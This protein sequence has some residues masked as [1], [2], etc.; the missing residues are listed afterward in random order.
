ML[1]VI[2]A[3]VVVRAAQLLDGL[4]AVLLAL[5]AGVCTLCKLVHRGMGGRGNVLGLEMLALWPW[6]ECEMSSAPWRS[7]CMSLDTTDLF[8]AEDIFGFVW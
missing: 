1:L 7:S 4:G 2:L 8:P 6:I 5:L 3:V